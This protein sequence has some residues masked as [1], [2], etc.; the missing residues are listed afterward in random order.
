M[1]DT[2]NPSQYDRFQR[3]REQPF[4][5]LAAMIE[6]RPGM[7]VVDLGCGTGRLTAQLHQRLRAAE[8]LGI[9][10]SG[11]M[12]TQAPVAG[13]LRFE[14]GT[15]EA[16]S[17]RHAYD[18]V[19]SNAALHWVTEHTTLIP[20]LVAALTPGGQIAFQVP[21]MHE[22]RSHLL[23]EALV[24]EE[25]FR[26]ALGGWRR[27]QPVLTPAAYARLLY[28]A[29]CDAPAVRLNVY[30]HLLED[31]HSVVE[32][33]KGTLLTEYERHLPAELFGRFLDEY[34]SR[35]L[36]QL[37]DERPYFFPYTRILCWGRTRA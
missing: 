19:F 31:R 10:R 4:Q 11:R 34:T 6:A 5:D 29:G 16:F 32:W 13:G 15:I 17:A 27:P 2:W 20:R 25:P 36:P 21:D 35:L 12:L 24:Q 8:T 9:D 26:S 3:E 1:T 7:R 23:A 22:S 14:T 33:M 28:H 37:E 18:L 30:P